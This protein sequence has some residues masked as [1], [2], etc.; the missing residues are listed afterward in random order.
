MTLSHSPSIVRDGLVLYVDAANPKSYP[1]TGTNWVD[2]SGKGIV[3]TL[4]NSPTLSNNALQ[5]RSSSLQY[6]SATINEGVLKET[7]KYG[8]WS[9]EV[10]FKYVSLPSTAESIIVGRSGCH[11]GIQSY[12]DHTIR[13]DIKTSQC[14]TGY[15]TVSATMAIGNYYHAVMAYS[16]GTTYAYLNGTYLGSSTINLATYG[17]TSYSNSLLINGYGIS[18][19]TP[20]T[21]ISTVKAYSRALSFEEV[22][23]NYNAIR[24]RG[25]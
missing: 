5:F 11:G 16:N 18:N 17:M 4:Y 6:A 2:M 10:F 20:N 7:N 23:K 25:L 13:F 3:T 14:W 12:T 22:K 8:Q 21:D 1:G 15:S 24:G 9:L 19:Y